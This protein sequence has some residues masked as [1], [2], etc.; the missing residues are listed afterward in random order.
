[1]LDPMLVQV[2]SEGAAREEATAVSGRV[3]LLGGSLRGPVRDGIQG[4][5][6]SFIANRKAQGRFA[7]LLGNIVFLNRKL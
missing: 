1:M 7:A 5:S 2:R 6:G 3:G 4:V